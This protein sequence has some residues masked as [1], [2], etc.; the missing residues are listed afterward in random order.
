MKKRAL[1]AIHLKW[2]I[3]KIDMQLEENKKSCIHDIPI[4]KWRIACTIQKLCWI[5]NAYIC[6]LNISLAVEMSII[7]A[8]LNWCSWYILPKYR[9]DFAY[10][11]S[12]YLLI[13][14]VSTMRVTACAYTGW[15]KFKK[16]LRSFC[17]YRN[18]LGKIW[19]MRRIFKKNV[20]AYL[21]LKC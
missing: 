2:N 19:K 13:I 4:I 10:Q 7:R 15:R 18:K 5:T 12:P 21:K 3:F 17:C 8:M 14:Y 1:A 20:L 6:I 11:Y 9:L 16:I